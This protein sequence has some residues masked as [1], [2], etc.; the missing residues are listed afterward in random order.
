MEACVL[1]TFRCI[2]ARMGA[3]TDYEYRRRRRRSPLPQAAIKAIRNPK[4]PSGQYILA[5]AIKKLDELRSQENDHHTHFQVQESENDH[6]THFQFQE[7]ENN[8]Y[9]HLQ[10]QEFLG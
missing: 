3:G 4:C 5:E 1:V 6:H 9:T 10:F 8:H 2:A 7:S